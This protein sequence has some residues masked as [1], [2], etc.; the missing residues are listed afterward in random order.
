MILTMNTVN[1][2]KELEKLISQWRESGRTPSILLHSCCAPC[3]SYCL[4]FLTK[5]VPVTVFYFNPNI[6]SPEEYAFRLEEQKRLISLM[7]FEH[8]VDIIEGRYDPGEFFSMAEGLEDAPERGPR[9]H[10][11]YTMRLK[12][13]ARIA[14]E[15]GFDYFATTLT[16]SPLKPADVINGIGQE[17]DVMN[18]GRTKYLPTDFKKNGGYLRSIEL[19]KEYSL[20]RQNYCGCVFSKR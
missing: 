7:P 19:S 18:T 3:S 10:R 20:Y 2:H 12:E 4:E 15:Q 5:Y 11:C 9:C 6:T 16:L 13:T 1:Y 14:A 17:L 8:P